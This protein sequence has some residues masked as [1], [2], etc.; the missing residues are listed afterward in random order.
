VA[1]VVATSLDRVATPLVRYV[2]GDLVQVAEAG[3]RN[4][5]SV[6]PI[7]GVEGRLDDAL[8]RPDGA[9]VTAGALDRALAPIDSLRAWQANQHVAGRVDVD[10]VAPDGE[11]VVDHVRA[12]LT[13][14]LGGLE[15]AVRTATGVPIEASGAFR[16]SRR[17]VPLDLARAFEVGR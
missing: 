6:A 15:V 7:V 17:H 9:L 8:V 10:V 12:R 14:L 1:L 5:T 16:A 4:W 13:P 3:P 2:T 11:S